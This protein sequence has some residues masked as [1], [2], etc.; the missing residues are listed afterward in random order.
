MS[1]IIAQAEA[2]YDV[3]KTASLIHDV[4]RWSRGDEEVDPH[5][6]SFLGYNVGHLID[7]ELFPEVKSEAIAAVANTRS[8]FHYSP[9]SLEIAR[10]YAHEFVPVMMS[11]LE[12]A[13]KSG[14]RGLCPDQL[15]S[16]LLDADYGWLPSVRAAENIELMKN[17]QKPK[18]LLKRPYASNMIKHGFLEEGTGQHTEYD[19]MF[20]VA[21]AQLV[22]R[23]QERGRRA[24]NLREK[25]MVVKAAHLTAN[26]NDESRL[27]EKLPDLF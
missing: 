21:T 24:R 17:N 1:E 23:F 6:I 26:P 12:T 25:F 20:N 11:G 19:L 4:F 16:G 22:E 27:E 7:V 10:S 15:A 9:I 8:K 5:I 13:A 3:L 18:P 2:K 14:F